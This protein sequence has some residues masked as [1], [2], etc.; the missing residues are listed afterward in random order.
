MKKYYTPILLISF[1]ALL[2]ILFTSLKENVK[3][4]KVALSGPGL[5]HD[6]EALQLMANLC[7]TC[8]NPDMGLTHEQRLAPPMFKVREHYY[9]GEISK[10]EFV[11]N[12]TAFVQNPTKEAS[13]M[14]GAIRNFGLMPKPFFKE[15]DVN[16]IAAYIYDNDLSSDAWYKQ[17]KKLQ[18]K[19]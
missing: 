19:D 12:I 4:T 8:H 3:Q 5:L 6:E 1:T 14:P 18:R 17:W 15:S 10:Q 7:F 2:I 13:R 9:N 11:T 16:K